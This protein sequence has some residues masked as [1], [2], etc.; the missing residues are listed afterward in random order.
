[1]PTLTSVF[2][3]PV[4][5]LNFINISIWCGILFLT[6]IDLLKKGKRKAESLIILIPT[7]SPTG[8]LPS[9]NNKSRS[10]AKPG[11]QVERQKN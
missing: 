4:F 3:M 7:R 8:P 2:E 9:A 10:E 1:M 5:V 6:G 11:T